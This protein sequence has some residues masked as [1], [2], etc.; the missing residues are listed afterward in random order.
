M[1]LS[2]T[3]T[4]N[5]LRANHYASP[6]RAVIKQQLNKLDEH[7]D[8][9]INDKSSREWR[10][11][12]IIFYKDIAVREFANECIRET[13]SEIWRDKQLCRFAIKKK[14]NEINRLVAQFDISIGRYLDHIN[15]QD[16]YDDLIESAQS[17]V[18]SRYTAF[19]AA[20]LQ[21]LCKSSCKN[22]HLM[23]KVICANLV[24]EVHNSQLKRDIETYAAECPPLEMFMGMY[25]KGLENAVNDLR[26]LL[27]KQLIDK[28]EEVAPNA[29][30]V[31]N[32]TANTLIGYLGKDTGYFSDIWEKIIVPR[33]NEKSMKG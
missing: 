8:K 33:G 21:L 23:A 17:F 1:K 30:E 9:C 18:S 2:N 28:D 20:T 10:I 5:P 14:C 29:D 6:I 16:Q 13:I 24:I 11:Y 26:S 12:T 3:Y 15:Q 19:Y 32:K 4:P 27:A 7:T 25:S 22:P 31:V